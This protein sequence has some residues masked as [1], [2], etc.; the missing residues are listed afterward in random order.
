MKHLLVGT[1]LAAALAGGAARAH[2][3]TTCAVSA[4]MPTLTVNGAPSTGIV[5]PG[6]IDRYKLVLADATEHYLWVQPVNGDVWVQVCKVGQLKGAHACAAGN[7]GVLPELCA[8]EDL[9]GNPGAGP[10]L[11]GKGTYLVMVKHCLRLDRSTGDCDY[12]QGLAEPGMVPG[13][14]IAYTAAVAH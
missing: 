1:L 12:S 6:T 9:E 8:V 4:S 11:K 13:A 7:F 3:T 14:P 5:E 10:P 2:H